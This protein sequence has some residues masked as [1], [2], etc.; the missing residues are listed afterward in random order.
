M[1]IVAATVLLGLVEQLSG[2][3]TVVRPRSCATVVLAV[4]FH[5]GL[6]GVLLMASR[7]RIAT[8]AN[9]FWA[10]MEAAVTVFLV[11]ELDDLVLFCVKRHPVVHH[12]LAC[13]RVLALNGWHQD[14]QT[15]PCSSYLQLLPSANER[16]L[17]Q[18]RLQLMGLSTLRRRLAAAGMSA[19]VIARGEAECTLR[20]QQRQRQL[21]EETSPRGDVDFVAYE[22]QQLQQ[23]LSALLMDRWA[24]RCALV[25]Q[26][27]A[28]LRRN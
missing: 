15:Y 1:L 28:F 25:G 11:V 13:I 5:V 4:F 26:L 6:A 18:S 8:V 24:K 21:Q 22:Q 2:I 20:C 14:K 7:R 17:Q 19:G 10:V 23:C 27:Q 9:D 3:Y 12:S 16:G